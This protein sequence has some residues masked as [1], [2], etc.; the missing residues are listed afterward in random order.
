MEVFYDH[1]R[2]PILHV[3]EIVGLGHG[4]FSDNGHGRSLN[5]RGRIE[6]YLLNRQK[7]PL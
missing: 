7:S 4:H 1:N 3:I 5:N 6:K 2:V